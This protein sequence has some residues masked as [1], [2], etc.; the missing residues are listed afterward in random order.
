MGN[1][2]TYSLE[3]KKFFFSQA[4]AEVGDVVAQAW[5]GR[6][7]YLAAYLRLPL[8]DRQKL[9]LKVMPRL[10]IFS[11]EPPK[12]QGRLRER[13]KTKGLSDEIIDGVL[14]GLVFN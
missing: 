5:C 8:E 3:L 7:A 10:T 13:L 1:W 11:S 12:A 6:K 2:P 4:T 14:E 9:Y